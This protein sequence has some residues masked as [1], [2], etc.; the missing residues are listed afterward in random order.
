M[1]KRMIFVSLLLLTFFAVT[2]CA[3]QT[4]PGEVSTINATGTGMVNSKPDTM[5]VRITVMTEGKDKNVQE[6]NAEKTQK[7]IDALKELGLNE[8]EIKTDNVSFNP[9]RKWDKNVGDQI[10]GYRAENTLY[11]ISKQIEKAGLIADIG[12]KNGA[13]RVSNISFTLSEEGKANILDKAIENAVLDAKK[14]ADASAKAAGVKIV[15]VKK[16]DVQK[17]GQP[18]I[19]YDYVRN[20]TMKVKEEAITPVMPK[21]TEYNVTVHVSFIIE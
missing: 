1:K 8:E 4:P 10:V 18:P 19:Y 6:T 12:V 14:Q 13:E 9:I 11:V 3:S 20:S 21:D 17:Q 15:G 5:E 2:G 7:V 16:I